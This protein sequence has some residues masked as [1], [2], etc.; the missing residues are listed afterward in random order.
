[1]VTVF[2]YFWSNNVN[3]NSILF[4]IPIDIKCSISVIELIY[5]D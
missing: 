4:I 5:L 1:M 3:I 2:L